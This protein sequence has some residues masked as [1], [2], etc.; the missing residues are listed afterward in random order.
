MC[1]CLGFV[2]AK[3][4]VALSVLSDFG[5]NI[6]KV[7]AV[8]LLCTSDILRNDSHCCTECLERRWRYAKSRSTSSRTCCGNCSLNQ[9]RTELSKSCTKV[10]D[11]KRCV[12]SV[13]SGDDENRC[14]AKRRSQSSKTHCA[15]NGCDD[16]HDRARNA[17]NQASSCH[18]FIG[19]KSFVGPV[20]GRARCHVLE[21]WILLF[22]CGLCFLG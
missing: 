20:T 15:S 6:S 14:Y 11:M 8:L 12:S 16:G 2:I 21:P 18:V 4:A 9:S 3:L 19:S 17:S 13:D 7:R 10:S 1:N 5:P 22:E